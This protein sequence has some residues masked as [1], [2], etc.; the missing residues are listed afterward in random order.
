MAKRNPEKTVKT[1]QDRYLSISRAA[2]FCSLSVSTI[3]NLLQRGKLRALRPVAGR[4]VIDRTEL[5]KFVNQSTAV[6]LVRRGIH[7][8]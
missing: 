8:G 3:R 6:P 4:V 2:A 5:E 7:H 1:I